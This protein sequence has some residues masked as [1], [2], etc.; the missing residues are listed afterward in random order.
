[1]RA[2]RIIEGRAE[3]RVL[4]SPLAHLLT[5]RILEDWEIA[6]DTVLFPEE[7]VELCRIVQAVLDEQKKLVSRATGRKNDQI[8]PWWLGT[9]LL[10]IFVASVWI[11]FLAIWVSGKWRS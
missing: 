6:R 2:E 4:A 11:A 9:A 3:A 8:T 5:N 1:M 7:A 10:W